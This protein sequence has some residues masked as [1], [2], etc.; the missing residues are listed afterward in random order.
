MS[1]D[2][3]PV[4][5]AIE[6]AVPSAT[7]DVVYHKMGNR[8][9]TAGLTVT[10]NFKGM[11]LRLMGEWTES[12]STAVL[13]ST[14]ERLRQL[15]QEEPGF[16]PLVV[17][18]YFAAPQRKLL[19]DAG[20]AFIDLAGNVYIEGQTVY[21]SRVSPTPPRARRIS[22]PNPFS[23]KASLVARQLLTEPKPVGVLQLSAVIEVT[24]GYVSKVLSRL[25]SLGYLFRNE[26]QK[27]IMRD[28]KSLL[29]DWAAAYDY[30]K[31]RTTGYFCR[32]HGVEAMLDKLR[33]AAI[34]EG[35]A[36]TAQAG[37]H[38]VAP[39][40]AFDRVDV[41]T[42]DSGVRQALV[43]GLG[44]EPVTRGANVMLWDPYY[45]H[46]V[47]FGSREVEGIRVVSDIQLYLDLIKYPLRG[48]EQA[49]HLYQTLLKPILERNV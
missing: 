45:K 36:L 34:Q 18:P 35:Y 42:A 16:L 10:L 40:A 4:R 3:D 32:A 6:E 37:A 2:P 23:D 7:A 39:Y 29:Q 48:P 26:K 47:F 21:I 8:S 22:A 30:A 38:L 1:P 5:R 11:R 24:P 27:L 17:A 49:E 9:T 25:E 31:N 14:A 12:P 43:D 19:A 46:S 28:A 33:T 41:Y 15:P 20:I 13:K 44:L